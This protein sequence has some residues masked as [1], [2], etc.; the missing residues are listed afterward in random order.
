MS[1]PSWPENLL[2]SPSSRIPQSPYWA[3]VAGASV[4]G[5]TVYNRTLLPC[6]F[7]SLEA[8]YR[9]LKTH[10]QLWDVSCQKQVEFKGRDAAKLAQMITPRPLAG[11][12]IG[13]CWYVPA[14]D[15]NGRM[16]NDPVLLKLDDD[17]FWFSIADSDMVLYASGVTAG[18]SLEVKISEPDI[19]PLAV[20]GPKSEQLVE[21]VFGN[22]P[23]KLRFFEFGR[24][25][26]ADT[27]FII[28][29]SGWS[30]QS[31]FEIYVDGRKYGMQLWNELFAAGKDLSVRAGCPN[32]IDR[33]V[34]GLLSYGG[35]MTREHSPY[36]CGLERYFDAEVATGC[37]GR[38]AL[39]Q[40]KE[41]GIRRQ[42]RCLQI[43]G[44]PITW[45]SKKWPISVGGNYAGNV[46][47]AVWSEDLNTNVAIAMVEDVYW[48][49]GTN[50]NVDINGEN[51]IATVQARFP[52]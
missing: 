2:L 5:V 29:R 10:V 50:L 4:R 19:F 26:F 48:D 41:A 9:H 33:V 47:A 23:A 49:T 30:R 15:Q 18:A 8:D 28:A 16:I 3:G 14:V 7:E 51:R 32:Y 22:G 31:G 27:E 34:G 44:E 52:V 46:S 36:E 42:I 45:C 38:D 24:F 39:L 25:P 40:E 43:A 6:V 1:N 20:Q 37:L 35:D 11:L 13:R 17:H 21:R 12:V